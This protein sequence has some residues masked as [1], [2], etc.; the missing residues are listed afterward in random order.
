MSHQSRTDNPT[1]PVPVRARSTMRDDAEPRIELLTACPRRAGSAT[2]DATCA[3]CAHE[4]GLCYDA[5]RQTRYRLCLRD[6]HAAPAARDALSGVIAGRDVLCLAPDVGVEAI[7]TLFLERGIEAAPVVD[8]DSRPL[9]VVSKTD[10]LRHYHDE[11]V[12]AEPAPPA[13][14]RAL[15]TLGLGRGFHT[16]RTLDATARDVMTQLVFALREDAPMER[17]AA[18]MA[19]EGVG[20]LVVLTSEGRVAGMLTAL[21]VARWA[22]AAS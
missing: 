3:G 21:D 16:E 20:Q 7:A 19:I 12:R 6:P 11:G 15:S 14:R 13:E 18:L 1:A 5:A 17:A 9:G 2:E 4:Q 10:L 8:E 22:A